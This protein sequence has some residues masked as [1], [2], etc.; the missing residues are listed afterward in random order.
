MPNWA[1]SSWYFLRYIDPKNN[2]SFADYDKLNY[3]MP[4]DWYNGGMEHTTLHL[5][6]SRFW[7]QFLS[8]CGY[9][10]ASEPYLKRTSHGMI[11]G[12]GGEKMSKSR[13]N[14]INPD[15]V[16]EKYGADVFRTYEMFIGPFDQSA[17]WDTKSISGTERFIKRIWR[18]FT[19][20]PIE[21]ITLNKNQLY[22]LHT[23]I[24]KI[25]EDID[26]LNLNTAIS[27][28]M[29]FVNE[30][31]TYKIIPLKAAETLILLMSPFAPHLS[32]ELWEIMG[33][34]S[35]I[36]YADWPKHKEECL[37]KDLITIVIQVNGKLR[38]E[39]SI[40]SDEDKE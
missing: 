19:H 17:S 30:M 6:Y 39:I 15:D 13:G 24:K 7:N 11:L 37:I 8:D 22:Q 28:L 18:L 20:T 34:T 27:Q 3:W 25:T 1:G 36:N 5:L 14:V 29:I 10:P 38:G 23:T 31:S 26:S 32:E 2:T 35:S 21:D 4:V 16:V 33:H 9:I 12:E 40:A